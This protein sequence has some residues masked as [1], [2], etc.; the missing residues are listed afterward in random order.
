MSLDAA[1]AAHTVAAA[2]DAIVTL[3]HSAKVT[4]WNRVAEQLL[5]F[6]RGTPWST[7]SP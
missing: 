6:S 3:D 1:L 4:S 2:D 7:G 5:G